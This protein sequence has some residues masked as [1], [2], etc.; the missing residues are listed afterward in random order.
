MIDLSPLRAPVTVTWQITG[1]CNLSCRH[2]LSDGAAD[3]EEMGFEEA[4]AL[5][6]ELQR[7]RVF[8]IN[9]GGGEPFLRE[10]FL[11]ILEY[12]T[13]KGIVACVSTNGTV[14]NER[15]VKRLK[16]LSPLYMQVSLDGAC[17]STNDLIRGKGSFERIIEG[18][19]LLRRSG[20]VKVAINTVVLRQNVDELEALYGMARGYGFI[21]RCTR[22]RP[23]G[24]GRGSWSGYSLRREELLKVRG[25]L[26]RHDD[27]RTGD[28]FFPITV[29]VRKGLNMCGAARMTCSISPSGSVYPCPF[30]TDK[31]FKA[32]NVL[33]D[34]LLPIWRHARS[35]EML[36]KIERSP[37]S[38][39]P[40][41]AQCHGGCPAL[42]YSLLGS[43][44][45]PD[46][47]CAMRLMEERKGLLWEA[48][49]SISSPL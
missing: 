9:F 41:F 32:G 21:L 30:L 46:P 40:F 43:L 12:T 10:D 6:E 5:I 27:V 13:R 33:T 2:C 26:Q 48:S 45:E 3:P 18:L 16:A 31:E 34:G 15:I 23:S 8:Q 37:C 4:K 36:R 1:R 20:F 11:D 7:H 49:L 24:R 39:C 42:A 17:P 19:E 38:S 28:S 22:F 47:E 29:G 44:E 25:F 14:L 35:F